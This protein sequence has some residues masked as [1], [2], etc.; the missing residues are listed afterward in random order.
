LFSS[1]PFISRTV[2]V[3][4]AAKDTATNNE[5]KITITSSSGLLEVEKMA[6]DAD[7]SILTVA[8][9]LEMTASQLLSGLEKRP[10]GFRKSSPGLSAVEK[11]V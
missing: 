4:V 6:K 5:Q 9:H 2:I 3:D 8:Q 10:A 11:H 7:V 1:I